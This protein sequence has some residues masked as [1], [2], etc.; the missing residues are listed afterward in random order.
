MR[1]SKK[2][3][4]A[5]LRPAFLFFYIFENNQIADDQINDHH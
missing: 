5:L 4:R 2:A 1:I 3:G